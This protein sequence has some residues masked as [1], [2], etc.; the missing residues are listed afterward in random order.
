MRP[1]T[2]TLCS[3]TELQPRP[4]FLNVF[5]NHTHQCLGLVL[6][7]LCSGITLSDLED[8]TGT[9]HQTQD[10]HVQGRCLS[11]WIIALAPILPSLREQ[12]KRGW[13]QIAV[14]TCCLLINGQPYPRHPIGSLRALQGGIPE[15]CDREERR[16]G[17]REGRMKERRREERK[18]L[19]CDTLG[20]C[21]SRWFCFRFANGETE[22]QE[23][24]NEVGPGR[25]S[26]FI[27]LPILKLCRP[28]LHY[29]IPALGAGSD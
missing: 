9:M 6:A 10:G 25:S 8:P 29:L 11:C 4:H 14:R 24:W 16:E 13:V 26:C 27:P 1:L 7:A 18:V 17:R 20:N 23:G 19:S 5:L 2:C 21:S 28:A 3:A 22:V 12:K 15:H